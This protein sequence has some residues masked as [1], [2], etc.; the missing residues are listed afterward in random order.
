MKYSSLFLSICFL[1]MSLYVGAQTDSTDA[2]KR[3][4]LNFGIGL[5]F[6]YGGIGANLMA[7]PQRN[8]GIF[9]SGGFALAGFGYNAGIK[10]RF[11]SKKA[12]VVT[13][14]LLA[15]YGYN[16]AILIT[17]NAQYNKLF[18]GPSFGAG[19]DIR[20][21]KPSSEGYLSIA[22]LVPVRNPDVQNYIDMLKNNYGASF[23][24][25]LLPVTF[26]VG[27]KFIMNK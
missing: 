26:S 13:P 17:N 16:T 8:I 20:S 22:I 25:S 1:F 12:S 14:A 9:V 18:Y 11:P 7:Y 19:I 21:K 27:Y 3:D 2:R 10:L 4:I 6:D 23:A 15:M 24:N 5:G